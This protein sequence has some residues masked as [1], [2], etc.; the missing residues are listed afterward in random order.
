MTQPTD[1]IEKQTQ[2]AASPDRV[3]EA[4]SNSGEFGHWFG[5]T[6]DGP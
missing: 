4:V 2:L 1:R 6:F 3:W 5:V